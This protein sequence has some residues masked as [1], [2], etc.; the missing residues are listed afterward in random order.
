MSLLDILLLLSLVGVALLYHY[1]N[2]K[3]AGWFGVGFYTLQLFMLIGMFSQFAHGPVVSSLVFP[4]Q[5]WIIRWEMSG[6]GWFFAVITVGAALFA[7]WYSA[8]EWGEKQGE[9]RLQHTTLALN[10]AAMLLL[11][12][13][14]DFLS[15]FIGWEV[16]SWASFLIMTQRGG[17]A[18]DAA[19]RYL[20]Y[21]M[22]GAMSLLAAIALIYLHTGSFAF[23]DF[24]AALPGF[25]N[26]LK[27]AL[28]L[29][30][31]AGFLVK[32]AVMPFHLWQ[33]DAYSE[34]PGAGAAFL[35]AIAG[36]MG[37]FALAAVLLTP[38]SM[39]VMRELS[40]PFTFWQAH[41]ALAWLAAITAII[42][43]YI[44]LQQTDAR[45]LLAWHGIGQG[46]FMLL[47][48]AVGTEMSVAGGLLHVFNY[49]TYQAALFL[50]VVAVIHR[51]GTADLDRLG[52]LIKRMPL[53]YVAL[54]MGI[55]GLAGLPPMNG[56][57]SK[58]LVYKSLLE[59]GRPL[60][61]VAA[62]ISTLGTILSVYKLIHNIFL[63]QL[64]QE[65]YAVKEVPWSMTLPMLALGGIGFVTGFMP[66]LALDL[67]A[68]AQTA[69]GY[70]MLPYHLGG[71]AWPTGGLNMLWV[72]GI[73]L[74]GIGIGALIFLFLGNRRYM[75]HQWD[76]YAGGH[77]LGADV[78]Y[79][80]SHNFY[81]GVMRVIGPWFINASGRL[82]Q[83]LSNFAHVLGGAFHSFYRVAYTPLYLLV[84]TVLA[85][86][87][88][89]Q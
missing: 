5:D 73:L 56:F 54:L 53:T 43:T 8:G 65:H 89:L 21:A 36:R 16:V 41:D 47:G 64:R 76:N 3:Q 55:I 59:D 70:A 18:A 2:H 67:V 1:G 50:A 79:Q 42:P 7:S 85:L 46:G 61:L 71:V 9:M 27:A 38:A 20:M 23:A 22:A 58:W 29:L 49:A 19:F 69:L 83:G 82:E 31:C 4:A 25:S 57:V 66:G 12:S 15:L 26:G 11:L 84:V 88:A 81:P 87:W 63:G 14:G 17:K 68:P 51:T 30:L 45:M 52:G 34:T 44:A 77:F 33:A 39:A 72:V 86:V 74:Y 28:I 35:N 40:V 32:M 24:H 78:P 37:L 10:V 48:L 75:T 13:S 60:L 80:Y 6:L 62:S